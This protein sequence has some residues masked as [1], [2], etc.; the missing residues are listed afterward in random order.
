[1]SIDRNRCSRNTF[2][3]P[4]KRKDGK[5][6]L[7]GSYWCGFCCRSSLVVFC[8]DPTVRVLL[9]LTCFALQGIVLY[10]VFCGFS[11]RYSVSCCRLLVFYYSAPSM[12]LSPSKFYYC[13]ARYWSCNCNRIVN[14]NCTL[15]IAYSILLHSIIFHFEV[16]FLSHVVS[17]NSCILLYFFPAVSYSIVFA[18]HDFGLRSSLV[19]VFTALLSSFL[20]RGASEVWVNLWRFLPHDL[21][22]QKFPPCQNIHVFNGF[23]WMIWTTGFWSSHFGIGMFWMKSSTPARCRK[24]LDFPLAA[25]L[26]NLG[27]NPRDPVLFHRCYGLMELSSWDF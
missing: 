20:F 16:V 17:C 21:V 5:S 13:T 27:K 3:R 10:C 19:G 23:G 18:A 6:I 22:L 15:F 25:L 8:P 7:Q 11:R 4:E 2:E 14:C 26:R 24:G 9:A 1:M 12:S